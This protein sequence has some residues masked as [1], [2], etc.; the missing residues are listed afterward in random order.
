MFLAPAKN[1]FGGK[2]I[3]VKEEPKELPR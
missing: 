2:E 3:V 1:I